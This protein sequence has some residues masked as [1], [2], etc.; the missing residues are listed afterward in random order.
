[1]KKFAGVRPERTRKLAA[2]QMLLFLILP[3][4]SVPKIRKYF[5]GWEGGN[6]CWFLRHP[7]PRLRRN[8]IRTYT[9]MKI[10]NQIG[11]SYRFKYLHWN[12]KPSFW[13][14][15]SRCFKNVWIKFV[16]LVYTH[17]I[18]IALV[19]SSFM[20][21][22]EESSRKRVLHRKNKL[23]SF[24][25]FSVSLNVEFEERPERHTSEGYWRDVT[26]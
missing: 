9:K 7:R 11:E 10:F 25:F 4:Q 16:S 1:M 18:L 17:M 20:Y 13:R 2:S 24:L 5:F 12:P 8:A 22:M 19:S 21:K 26:D 14:N 3:A 15:L 23:F 6:R